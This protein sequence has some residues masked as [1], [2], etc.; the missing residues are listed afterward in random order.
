MDA[1]DLMIGD[2]VYCRY[3]KENVKVV[4]LPK[5]DKK[6]RI[7]VVGA[8]GVEKVFRENYIEPV[9]LTDDI[10]RKNGFRLENYNDSSFMFGKWWTRSD[11]VF[12]E[13]RN[14][15]IGRN[16]FEYQYVHQLQHAL[17]ICKVKSDFVL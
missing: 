5:P 10:L 16:N 14:D 13:I 11:F 15:S 4:A 9:A 2:W 1:K 7:V 12:P 8:D 6:H 3:L 17:S